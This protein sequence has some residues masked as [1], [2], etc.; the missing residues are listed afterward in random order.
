MDN[1]QKAIMIGVGLFITIIIIAIV[2]VVTG[3]GQELANNATGELSAMS[4]QLQKQ[5]TQEYDGT[6]M[7]GSQVLASVKKYHGDSKMAI[8]LTNV[9]GKTVNLG[10]LISDGKS[11][12]VNNEVPAVGKLTS[13]SDMSYY[14]VTT[15]KYDAN[16]IK[17]NDAVV[18]ISFKKQG[19][20]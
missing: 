8:E 20:K 19:V 18:G 13:T 12:S 9:N 6:V 3:M 15:A 7:T 1:A 4:A 17:I 10:G 2:M 5:L 14:I 11:T 16:L